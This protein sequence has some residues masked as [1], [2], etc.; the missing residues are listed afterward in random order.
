MIDRDNVMMA[1][2]PRLLA[3]IDLTVHA[4]EDEWVVRD[5]ISSSRYREFRRHSIQNTF[6]DI[7]FPDAE[8]LENWKAL[9]EFRN[10]MLVTSRLPG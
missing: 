7:I 1:M 6:K 10:R 3:E 5:G 4:P 2:T 9:P 8:E